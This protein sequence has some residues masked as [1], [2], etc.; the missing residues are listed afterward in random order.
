MSAP[1]SNDPS[2]RYAHRGNLVDGPL[3]GHLIRMAAPMTWGIFA[4]IS[5]QLVDLFFIA[6]MG[7]KELAA[8][9][10]TLP[11]SMAV[12]SLILG[13]SIGM[14]SV[15]SR[16]IGQEAAGTARH[17]AIV[18]ITTHGLALAFLTGCGL[19]LLGLCFAE[20]LMRV[21]GAT[22]DMIPIINDYLHTWFAG[23]VFI[24]MP[25]IGNAALRATGNAMFPAIVMTVASVVNAILSPV[26]IFGLLG[27]PEMG[28]KGA[29]L[30]TVFANAGA[31]IAGLYMLGVRM[32]MIALRPFEGHLLTDSWK[33]LLMVGLPA[34]ITNMVQPAVN[35]LIIAILAG[36]GAEAVAAF[37]V[38][39]RV[40]AFAF[41]VVMGLAGGMA[42][43]IGQNWG[44]KRF[45]RV[46]ETLRKAFTFNAA[47]SLVVAAALALFGK[48]IAG[49]FS[50]DPEIIRIAALYFLIVPVTYA[51]GNLVPGW[52]SA[53][54][55][56]GAPQRAAAVIFIKHLVVLVPACYI[57]AHLAGAP[58]L[59][60]GIAATNLVA[61]LAL[62]AYGWRACRRFEA[63]AA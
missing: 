45:D 59:F 29:A 5:F 52:A 15:L 21:M 1:H 16:K 22:D 35:G 62:N 19:A 26:L 30:A 14:A 18:R 31:M 39:T 6:Q 50:G 2:A 42:P 60:A 58:G 53:F 63:A 46:R 8:V 44:A 48:G 56:I 40:E 20:P 28:V 27:A 12:F 13:L 57:G 36:S 43:I 61:G 17:A 41:I 32:K 7:T 3:T 38:V 37:G 51:A 4:I 11:V 9:S 47:W 49:V 34:G 23:A 24:T 25:M 54:N 55:A 10:F 33:Q